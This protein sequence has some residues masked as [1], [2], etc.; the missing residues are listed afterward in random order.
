M[1]DAT[2]NFRKNNS[3]A[4]LLHVRLKTKNDVQYVHIIIYFTFTVMGRDN[5][6]SFHL[7]SFFILQLVAFLLRNETNK[8]SLTISTLSIVIVSTIT[9]PIME[10]KVPT[11]TQCERYKV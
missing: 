5:A 10:L 8:I 4:F 3:N 2:Y 1:D 6:S 11:I 7:F 9:L